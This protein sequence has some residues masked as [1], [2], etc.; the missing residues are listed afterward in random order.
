MWLAFSCCAW[1][2]EG[3]QCFRQTPTF[4]STGLIHLVLIII[5][6]TGILLIDFDK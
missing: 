2:D 1:E 6:C 3:L 5:A 4:K